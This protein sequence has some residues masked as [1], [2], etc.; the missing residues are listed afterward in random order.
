MAFR[1]KKDKTQKVRFRDLKDSLESGSKCSC[2]SHGQEWQ[3]W[4][5]DRIRVSPCPINETGGEK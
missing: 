2:P 4:G 1:Y 3:E 5:L